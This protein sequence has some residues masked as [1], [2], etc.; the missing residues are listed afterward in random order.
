M[1]AFNGI[2]LCTLFWN[3]LFVLS[4]K[5]WTFFHIWTHVNITKQSPTDKYLV[6]LPQFAITNSTTIKIF[7]YVKYVH[8]KNDEDFPVAEPK[9]V[10][11]YKS[12]EEDPFLHTLT[13]RK[14]HQSFTLS[15][16]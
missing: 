5:C 9:I 16:S 3:L 6:Y 1:L 15:H 11:I 12:K 7:E 4:H 2:L 14:Y 13:N 8:L 10:S